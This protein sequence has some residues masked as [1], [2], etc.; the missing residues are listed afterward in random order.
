MEEKSTVVDNFSSIVVLSQLVRGS[1]SSYGQSE[2]GVSEQAKEQDQDGKIRRAQE[3]WQA[4]LTQTGDLAGQPLFRVF[5]TIVP[6]ESVSRQ[7][8]Q[9]M[10]LNFEHK[11]RR[12]HSSSFASVI[13]GDALVARIHDET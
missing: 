10:K 9:D 4:V 5:E 12:V 13:E 8:L 11:S 2:D 3:S 7:E 1:A 6:S